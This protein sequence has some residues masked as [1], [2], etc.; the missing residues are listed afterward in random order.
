MVC[1]DAVESVERA[2]GLT[3]FPPALKR[4]AK[5]LCDTVQ[6]EIIVRD[7]SNANKQLGHRS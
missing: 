4:S 7:F 3:L 5:K 1:T 6:C 2:S